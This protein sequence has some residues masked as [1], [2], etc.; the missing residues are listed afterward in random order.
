MSR[1][2]D[3]KWVE[4]L[5]PGLTYLDIPYW[6]SFRTRPVDWSKFSRQLSF[7]HFWPGTNSSLAAQIKY[8]PPSITSL[9]IGRYQELSRDEVLAVVKALP[10]SLTSF[11][12]DQQEFDEEIAAALPR[13]LSYFFNDSH[14]CVSP[15]TLPSLPPTIANLK[16]CILAKGVQLDL[17]LFSHLNELFYNNYSSNNRGTI[18]WFQELPPSVTRLEM[19][20]RCIPV[21]SPDC[22]IACFSY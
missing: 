21:I 6:F 2:S 8:L 4:S 17:S 11:R 18:D 14:G 20:G 7:L 12:F 3:P 10:P 19:P 22:L 5:P 1:G 13:G 16:M 15:A 9:D